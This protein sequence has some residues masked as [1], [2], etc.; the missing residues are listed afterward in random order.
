M[1]FRSISEL[2]DVAGKRIL[3]RVDLNVPM[4]DGKVSDD[5]RI[6]AV[7]P[8]VNTLLGKGPKGQIV[9]DM[10]LQP[11]VKPLEHALGKTVVFGHDCIG[12]KATEAV[13]SG[14][15]II[16]LENVRFHKG[17]EEN[18]ANFVKALAEQGDIFVNDAFSC[19]HRAHAS[20]TGLAKLLPSYAGLTM[21]A[22]LSA[23]E[24]ALSAPERPVGA[25]VGGAKVSSKLDVLTNL[26]AKV[27]HLIIGGGMANTFLAALGHNVGASL[28]EHELTETAKN[29]LEKAEKCGCKI[30]LPK[31][32]VVAKEFADNPVSL[33]T[34]PLAELEKDEMI[35]DIGPSSAQDLISVIKE[36][37]TIIWNGPLGAFE[38]APFDQATVKLAQAVATLT[39]E[40]ELLSVAGG[41]DTVSAL[42]LAG[43]KDSFSHV[44]TAGG[45]FLEWMEGKELP[46]VKALEI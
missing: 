24:A 22:E 18:Q 8:T 4:Q 12:P 26:V 20:T 28:C 40:G 10:S 25:V 19:A 37:R 13:N 17:E 7:L 35:L 39:L 31:D 29:I 46:G 44:S 5:N 38:I 30:H 16:L 27:E 42:N 41:G 32:V 2:G 1:S 34:I 33:R 45:A 9:P 43:V 23:L 11:L 14:A 6:Q 15:E 3:V 36:C 21:S